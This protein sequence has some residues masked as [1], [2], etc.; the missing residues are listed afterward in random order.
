MAVRALP[1]VTEELDLALPSDERPVVR[2]GGRLA[3]RQQAERRHRLGLSFQVERFDLLDL[4]RRAD[5]RAGRRPDEHLAR[6]SRLLEPCGHVHRV[7]GDERAALARQDLARVHADPRLQLELRQRVAHLRRGA[8]RTQRVV[9]VRDRHAEHRHHRIADELLDRPAVALD[10]R[11]HALEVPAQPALEHLR[12]GRV[13]QCSRL[14]QVAEDERDGLALLPGGAG[15]LGA[16]RRLRRGRPRKSRWGGGGERFVLLEDRALEATQLLA[17]LQPELVDEQAASLLVCRERVRLAPGPVQRQHQLAAQAL[18]QRVLPDEPLELGHELGVPAE[19]EIGVDPLLQRCQ[20]LLLQAGTRGQRERHVELRERDSSPEGER[21]GEQRRGL[22]RGSTPGACHRLLEAPQVEL[23]VART[24]EVA[25]PLG[26][27]HV[28]AEHLP[29]LR[30]VHL[31]GRRGRLRRPPAP[32]LLDQAVTRNR[33]VRMQQQK[34]EQGARLRAAE[35]QDP[36]LRLDL[37]RP[38]DPELQPRVASFSWPGTRG[39]TRQPARTSSL[40]RQR[41][42]RRAVPR[43]AWIRARPLSPRSGGAHR[44]EGRARFPPAAFPSR[45]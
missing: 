44:A 3:D 23:A 27:D 16:R 12:I 33:L 7:A 37:Q 4:R 8:Q 15:R 19:L 45:R 24:D 2:T 17:R 35:L 38:Q 11:L 28:R 20:P 14:G 43:R 5:E 31:H 39:R 36:A 34:R 30:D 9:L 32:Q 40:D 42:R 41:R 1:R 21:F 13:A 22:G 25:G 29:K 10:N 26:D 6:R 18:A